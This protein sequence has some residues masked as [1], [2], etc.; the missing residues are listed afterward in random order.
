MNQQTAELK[1]PELNAPELNAMELRAFESMKEEFK[2]ADVDTK[3]DMY[4]QAEGLS[5]TQYKE[6]LKLFPLNELDRLEKAL[7]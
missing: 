6:L 3:I 2:T 1:A 5:H 4:I 7:A